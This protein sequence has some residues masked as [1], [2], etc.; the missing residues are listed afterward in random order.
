MALI[1]IWYNDW[2]IN[3]YFFYVICFCFCFEFL[4]FAAIYHWKRNAHAFAVGIKVEM[5]NNINKLKNCNKINLTSKQNVQLLIL[6]NLYIFV[7]LCRFKMRLPSKA[8]WDY[9]SKFTKCTWAR[10]ACWVQ[11]YIHL[12]VRNAIILY[13]TQSHRP[14]RCCI[15]MA[16]KRWKLLP[17]IYLLSIRLRLPKV[18]SWSNNTQR[19]CM[20]F[21]FVAF[22]Q[23]LAFGI[24]T[25]WTIVNTRNVLLTIYQRIEDTSIFKA[26]ESTYYCVI[27]LFFGGFNT[28]QLTNSQAFGAFIF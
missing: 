15:Q 1:A 13:Y 12:K 4:R 5:P 21:S 2:I 22:E 9:A 18:S 6:G 24:H 14:E 10:W 19:K 16:I 3:R 8:S 28:Y 20:T 27:A 7:L 26:N 11:I 23:H 25:I 17:Y